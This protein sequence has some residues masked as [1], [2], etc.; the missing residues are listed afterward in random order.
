MLAWLKKHPDKSSSKGHPQHHPPSTMAPKGSKAAAAVEATEAK[1]EAKAAAAAA[2]AA[3]AE[4]KKAEA[5]LAKAA[6]EEE[7]ALKKAAARVGTTKRGSWYAP[8]GPH[9]QISKK[10]RITIPAYAPQMDPTIPDT[11]VDGGSDTQNADQEPLSNLLEQVMDDDAPLQASATDADDTAG[12]DGQQA[13]ESPEQQ[14]PETPTQSPETPSHEA[15]PPI[16]T[17]PH[18]PPDLV[19]SI[20]NQSLILS[21]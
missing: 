9:E 18:Q 16:P 5:A 4:E 11:Q 21:L 12:E 3:A 7:A 15:C 20:V 14:S 8:D 19:C 10:I 13:S 1:A 17:T 6:T 2:K